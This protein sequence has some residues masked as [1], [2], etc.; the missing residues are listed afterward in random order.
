MSK[1]KVHI[2]GKMVEGKQPCSLCGQI[3]FSQDKIDPKRFKVPERLVR[4]KNNT[5]KKFVLSS[6][7]WKV[8]TKLIDCGNKLEVTEMLPSCKI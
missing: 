1:R 4:I 3:L 6:D 7:G 2:A 5:T 8:G